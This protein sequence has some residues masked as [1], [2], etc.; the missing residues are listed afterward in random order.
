MHVQPQWVNKLMFPPFIKDKRGE[1]TMTPR[2]VALV[3]RVA[4]LRETGLKACH[5]A[6]EFTLWRIRPLGR[7]EKHALDCSRLADPSREPADGKI[8]NL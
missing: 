5:C 2:L 8:F 3:K 4:E 7:R 1:P 6:E